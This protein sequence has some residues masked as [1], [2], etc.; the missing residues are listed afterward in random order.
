MKVTK[1]IGK[2]T[3]NQGDGMKLNIAGHDLSSGGAVLE[4]ED[5]SRVFVSEAHYA[6]HNFAEGD[7][8]IPESD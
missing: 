4:L 2:S 5:G 7:E 1:I 8:F 6:S 3:G